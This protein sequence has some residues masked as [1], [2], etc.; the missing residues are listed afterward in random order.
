MIYTFKCDC[1]PEAWDQFHRSMVEGPPAMVVC[2][3][4][5]SEMYRDWRAD[6]PMIDTSNCKDSDDIPE[7]HRVQRSQAPSSPEMEEARFN[8]HI[9]ERRKQLADGGNRGSIRHSH[10]VPADLFHGK[11][12][13]TGDRNYW[14]D[15]KNL[16]KHK[17]CKVD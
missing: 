16:N 6:S 12:R 4:C 10:S 11:I 14:A 1:E 2:G 3:L 9:T 7:Q 5:G 17:S 15:P 8:R 13:Q